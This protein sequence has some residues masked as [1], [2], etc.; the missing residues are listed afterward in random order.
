MKKLFHAIQIVAIMGVAAS[1]EHKD[2]CY[3]HAHLTTVRVEFDWRDAPHAD[4]AGM[5]LWF[6]P[7]DSDGE[8]T[9]IDL[10]GKYGGNVTI[11]RGRYKIITYNGDYET[12]H[13]NN[14]SEFLTHE[15]VSFSG[16]LFEPLG[17]SGYPTSRGEQ[18]S[19][20]PEM[21]WGCTAVE[22]NI[23]ESGVSYIC[24]PESEK[25]EYIGRPIERKELVI[26]LY[27]HELISTYTFEIHGIEDR[28]GI[29]STSGSLSSMSKS[30]VIH[31]ESVG[32]DLTTLPFG[33]EYADLDAPLT[34][35][36]LTFGCSDETEVPQSFLLYVW[37][38]D[39]TRW[40]YDFDVSEQI[41]NAPNQKQV[42]LVI[43]STT[44]PEPLELESGTDPRVDGWDSE[45]HDLHM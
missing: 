7:I 35:E 44:P 23:A 16:G 32:E 26:T 40:Y 19:V 33:V 39:G 43:H 10:R 29:S 12:I 20:C 9:H 3:H 28:D 34:G 22:V 25:D 18:V 6:Y 37:R 1:C 15:I 31:D 11:T 4:P 36:F 13:R 14:Y 30:L 2:L 17:Y 42:H 24:V 27:P 5:C 41:H 38:N 8:P 21:M 45:N